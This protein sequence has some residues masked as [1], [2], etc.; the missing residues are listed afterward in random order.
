M[1]NQSKLK[2]A[3][4]ATL[5]DPA[6]VERLAIASAGTDR[7][8]QRHTKSVL[9]L[10]Q[11]LSDLVNK[12]PQKKAGGP[13]LPKEPDLTPEDSLI[14]QAAREYTS[15]TGKRAA[16]GAVG[17]N[18]TNGGGPFVRFAATETGLS[19]STIIGRLDRMES[20]PRLRSL[21]NTYRTPTAQLFAGFLATL[22]KD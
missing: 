8:S 4:R 1:S 2:N 20:N 10:I 21:W 14:L 11:T 5:D 3:L 22:P 12:L 15:Q 13:P 6:L 16:N 18:I 17:H 7:S 19:A 9:G